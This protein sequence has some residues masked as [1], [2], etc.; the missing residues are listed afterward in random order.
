MDESDARLAYVVGRRMRR[1]RRDQELSQEAVAW[2][3]GIHRT[4]ISLYEHGER[5]PFLSS[6]VRLAGGLGVSPSTLL[7]GITWEGG[8][9][10]V[11][12]FVLLDQG[13]DRDGR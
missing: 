2:V 1:I 12:G 3:P 13:G 6:F 10:N 8:Q 11:G 4:Q 7:D 5:M 9:S